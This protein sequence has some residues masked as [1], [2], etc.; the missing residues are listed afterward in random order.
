VGLGKWIGLVVFV[1]SLY[2]VWQIRQ[3]LLLIFA[4]VVLATALDRLIRL[5]QQIGIKKRGFA[6]A[7]TLVLLLALVAGFLVIIVPPFVDQ[8]QQLV[9]FIPEGIDRAQQ[10]I[11]WL[12]DRLTQQPVPF[13]GLNELSEQLQSFLSQ[14]LGNLFSLFSDSIGIVLRALLVLVLSIM[15]LANPTLYR[16]G[17]ILLFPSFYRRRA[18]EILERCN[19]SLG[20]WATGI[21]FN[22]IVIAVFSGISLWILQVPLALANA[23]LAGL[24]TFIPNVGPTLSVIPPIALALLDAPW[25]AIAVLILYI[26]IQQLESNILTPLMMEKQVSLP[27]A[28]TLASQV[29]FASFFGFLGLF[30]A[31]PLMVVLQVWIKELLVKDILND[32]KDPKSV[33]NKD[34]QMIDQHHEKA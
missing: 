15:L 28:V 27:P 12:Q 14:Q 33:A 34:N 21:L 8:L 2:I 26:V 10:W 22:M 6:I 19:I 13:D 7:L 32:W 9:N 23:I 3:I 20:G 16:K 29:I 18:E 31:L 11:E 1:A 17:F 30:L 25:K 5:F 4:A 24:L